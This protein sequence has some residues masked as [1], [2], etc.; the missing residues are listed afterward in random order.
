MPLVPSLEM[1]DFNTLEKK[2]GTEDTLCLC[3]YSRMGLADD[4]PCPECGKI[5]IARYKGSFSHIAWIGSIISLTIAGAVTLLQ[6]G[7]LVHYEWT[8]GTHGDG[9]MLLPALPWLFVVLPISGLSIL[10]TVISVLQKEVK[11]RSRR[12]LIVNLIA[13]TLLPAILIYTLM[14]HARWP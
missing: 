1:F 7:L 14:A 10:L 6:I 9:F 8:N 3:G 5:T 4:V 13:V 11:R 12:I 2:I